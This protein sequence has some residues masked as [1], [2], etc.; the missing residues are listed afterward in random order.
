MRVRLLL[1]ENLTPRLALAVRRAY[2]EVD[3]LRVGEPDTPPLG[4]LDPAILLYLE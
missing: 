3:V 2:P 4:T 1:D